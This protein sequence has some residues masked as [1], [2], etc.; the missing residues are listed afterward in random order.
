VLVGDAGIRVEGPRRGGEAIAEGP[1]LVARLA[2]DVCG[3]DCS[4]S[5]FLGDNLYPAGIGPGAQGDI[6]RT[7][8]RAY[9]DLWSFTPRSYVVLGN[10]DW[11][12]YPKALHTLCGLGLCD[13]VGYPSRDRAQR[14]LAAVREADDLSGEAHFWD[15]TLGPLHAV[16]L[17]T[18]F[19]TRRCRSDDVRCRGDGGAEV[20]LRTAVDTML[21]GSDKARTVVFG[22]HPWVGTGEH[23][24]AGSYRDFGGLSLGRGD[25]L[26]SLLD[27]T[28][29]PAASLYVAGHDHG[30]QV[31]DDGQGTLS[32]V[33][34]AGGKA[35][36]P[37]TRT[38][39]GERY[40]QDLAFEAWC[41]LGF[42]VVEAGPAD[43]SVQV[44]T[45]VGPRDDESH[46]AECEAQATERR[47]A[48]MAA[49][50]DR[51]DTVLGPVAPG[52]DA[53]HDLRCVQ[54]SLQ[55]GAWSDRLPC[56]D[57]ASRATNEG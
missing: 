19:L 5:V 39:P 42:V 7:A 30:M 12:A 36:A 40:A 55:D 52:G 13:D 20:P 23:G 18:V 48:H 32:L 22:H 49:Q 46:L 17:D 11:G 34:G 6:D 50:Q 15:T 56:A 8:L 9:R 25:A 3:G 53:G 35:T 4:A 1:Q 29:R 27:T 21:A 33:I 28:V 44:Y 26:A 57:L 45:L 2:G 16:T 24:S 54:W 51:A 38:A 31:H 43:L 10:H 47:P 41:R 37:G 14:M